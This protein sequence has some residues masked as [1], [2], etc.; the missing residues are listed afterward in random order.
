M[1]P[2]SQQQHPLSV[3]VMRLSRPSFAHSRPIYNEP[4]ERG[5]ESENPLRNALEHLLIDDVLISGCRPVTNDPAH[6]SLLD[7][8]NQARIRDLNV[9]DTLLLPRSFG[10]IYL[11]E[12]FNC[13]ICISNDSPQTIRNVSVKVEL[14]TNAVRFPLIQPVD[15]LMMDPN[16]PTASLTL[17]LSSKHI[18]EHVVGQEMKELGIHILVCNVAYSVGAEDGGRDRRSF[19]KFYKFQVLNPLA[20]KTKANSLPDGRLFLEAQVQ[21]TTTDPIYLEKMFVD[22]VEGL[23]CQ[24]VPVMAP[25]QQDVTMATTMATSWYLGPQDTLQFLFLLQPKLGDDLIARYTAPLGRLEI[26]WR[27]RLGDI[28]RLQT[29][30]L[31]RKPPPVES[32]EFSVLKWSRED[33]IALLERPF[34]VECQVRNIDSKPISLQ[35]ATT[36]SK[37]S[38]ILLIGKATIELGTLE[39]GDSKQFNLRLFPLMTG[40]HRV[41]A[42]RLVDTNTGHIRDIS[43]QL[44]LLVLHGEHRNNETVISTVDVN[45]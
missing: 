34:Q 43:D 31:A 28:G 42:V 35:I 5:A 21:N 3:R 38:A 10:N 41:E 16:D 6:Q 9:T 36:K 32:I 14:Q 33:R 26:V 40:V 29:S 13:Y 7:R 19:K 11:G 15:G 18:I 37:M 27:S 23:E 12:T 22:P 30:Q 4:P 25:G 2:T 45:R 39:P 44:E 1:E 24:S 20:V 8:L 17:N